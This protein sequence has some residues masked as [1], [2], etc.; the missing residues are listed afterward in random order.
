VVVLELQKVLPYQVGT[1]EEADPLTV[2]LE[3]L[4]QQ[5]LVVELE[6]QEQAPELVAQVALE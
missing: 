1:V 4:E 2:L 3:P 6:R 5:I